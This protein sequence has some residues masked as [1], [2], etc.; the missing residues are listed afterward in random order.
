MQGGD[1]GVLIY[2]NPFDDAEV[3]SIV[4]FDH[5]RHRIYQDEG[6]LSP[7]V[8]VRDRLVE[9]AL[10]TLPKLLSTVGTVRCELDW[11]A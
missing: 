7:L 5:S 2:T 4:A 9:E 1:V 8:E 10:A 6:A 3:H 11:A